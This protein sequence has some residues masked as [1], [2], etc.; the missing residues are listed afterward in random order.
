MISC[1]SSA[2]A[3]LAVAALIGAARVQQ[4]VGRLQTNVTVTDLEGFS[5]EAVDL[6]LVLVLF[7]CDPYQ[8]APRAYAGLLEKAL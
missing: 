1:D 3:P 4:A 2:T 7:E 8:L 6:Q 5:F